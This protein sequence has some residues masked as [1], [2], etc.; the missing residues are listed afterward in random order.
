MRYAE[1]AA[2]LQAS[3]EA[4]QRRELE[5]QADVRAKQQE[6]AIALQVSLALSCTA[7]P[8]WY[9]N[10]PTACLEDIACP[11]PWSQTAF[12]PC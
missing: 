2:C 4:L 8:F 10:H 5:R 7:L 11:F 12:K 6:L 9:P 3:R 1:S